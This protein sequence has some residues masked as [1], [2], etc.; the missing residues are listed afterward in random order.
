MAFNFMA[1]AKRQDVKDTPVFPKYIGATLAHLEAINPSQE[2]LSKL[3]GRDAAVPQSYSSEVD[4]A[5][6]DGSTKKGKQVLLNFWF[7][8]PNPETGEDVPEKLFVN[9][10]VFLKGGVKLN[11]DKTKIQIVDPYGRFA[12]ATI[13]EFKGN[14]VP[15]YKD[16]KTGMM[17]PAG[18]SKTYRA[19]L[20]GE[21]SLIAVVKALLGLNQPI[22][23]VGNSFRNL[24]DEELAQ[25][26]DE[27]ACGFEPEEIRRIL[28]GH[29]GTIR[30]AVNDR[31]E[32]KIFLGVSHKQNGDYQTTYRT[33]FKKNFNN[34]SKI[35]AELN[36]AKAR[37]YEVAEFLINGRIP[38]A[39]IRYEVKATDLTTPQKP[40]VDGLI[41]QDSNDDGLPF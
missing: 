5:N 20:D 21:E 3:L 12:W 30:E 24:T 27:F 29:I 40:K 2:E 35:E 17:I 32:V 23:K 38:D 6:I 10:T 41:I 18:I 28:D 39:L 8:V 16:K 36:D 22:E 25:R 31:N 11:G 13:E 14:V 26:A 9:H 33:V 1:F 4:V 34:Y 37:G 7:S 19:A 15:Q